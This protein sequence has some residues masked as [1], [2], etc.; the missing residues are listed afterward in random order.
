LR[1]ALFI[2][3]TVALLTVVAVVTFLSAR[4]LRRYTLPFNPLLAPAENLLRALLILTCLGLGLLSGLPPERLGWTS[5][6]PGGDLL[7]AV[8]AGLTLP[9][10]LNGL[11]ALVIR[12]FGPRVYSESLVRAIL[13]RDRRQWA[14]VLLALIPA[15]L[16]EE[17]LFR[18]LLLGGFGVYVSPL[19][20][21]CV[22]SLLFG[23]LH[24]PQ[25]PWGVAGTALAGFSLSLLFLWRGGLLAPLVAHYLFNAIQITA[26]TRRRMTNDE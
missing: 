15:V 16:L 19:L 8:A 7:L 10:A 14:L 11:S 18:S 22:G 13:P 25:G 5:P 20:L 26:A 4:L 24:A 9:L 1:E 17:L 23:A 3:G 6:D 21:A 2:L 12:I